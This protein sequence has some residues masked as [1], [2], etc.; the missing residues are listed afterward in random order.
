MGV[1]DFLETD[2]GFVWVEV[3]GVRVYSCY[4]SPGDPFDVFET[5]ILLLEKSLREAI[6]RCLIGGDFNS[7]SPEWGKART[8]RRETLVGETVARNDLIVLNQGGEVTYRRGA[9][10]SIIDL[11]IASLQG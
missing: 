10:A 2:E 8:D 11:T 6:G 1:G 7:E 9:G 5:Q 3:A 4:F